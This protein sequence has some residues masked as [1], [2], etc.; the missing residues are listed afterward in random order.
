MG[1]FGNKS[2]GM[3]VA[4]EFKI[5]LFD[6]VN[7]ICDLVKDEI[8]IFENGDP[9]RGKSGNPGTKKIIERL[10]EPYN[11]PEMFVMC[12]IYYL[13]LNADP[14]KEQK[15]MLK[16]FKK[17]YIVGYVSRAT[18]LYCHNIRSL[19]SANTSEMALETLD[20]ALGFEEELFGPKQNK[21][22]NYKNGG[23]QRNR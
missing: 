16:D 3:S 5:L 9:S 20:T 10:D 21:N 14:K 15:A 8:G 12:R 17:G 7:N 13:F 6:N 22:T 4:E 2:N 19:Y 11:N 23:W 1:L 18:E